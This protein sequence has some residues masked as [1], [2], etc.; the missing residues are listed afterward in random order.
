MHRVGGVA[1]GAVRHVIVEC[2]PRVSQHLRCAA[3]L[4]AAVAVAVAPVSVL[5]R[6]LFPRPVR[7]AVA[8]AVVL[9]RRGPLAVV[10]VSLPLVTRPHPVLEC[11]PSLG[12]VQGLEV[13]AAGVGGALRHHL[14]VGPDAVEADVGVVAEVDDAALVGSLVG[15]LDPREAELVGDVAPDDFHHLAG[16]DEVST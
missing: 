6:Q 8:V 10:A 7:L 5:P 12:V 9:L 13:V 1:S 3:G 14:E 16:R 15:R 2:N 4:V 11:H